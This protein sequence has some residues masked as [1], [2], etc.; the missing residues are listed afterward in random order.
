MFAVDDATAEAIRRAVEQSGELAGVVEF[1]RH[2]PL[3]DDHA[4]ARSC[5]RAI[6]G[7]KLAVAVEKPQS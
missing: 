6:T 4:H 1:R 3:I 7:W 5:V 2:F